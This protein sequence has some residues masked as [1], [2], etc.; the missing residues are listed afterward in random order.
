[1][2]IIRYSLI[3]VVFL[4]IKDFYLWWEIYSQSGKFPVL[5]LFLLNISGLIIVLLNL[6]SYDDTKEEAI[7]LGIWS[8][9][10]VLAGV[11]S[12][13]LGAA[14]GMSGV[15][16]DIVLPVI[17]YSFFIS[18]AILYSLLIIRSQRKYKKIRVSLR[19]ILLILGVVGFSAVSYILVS[20]QRLCEYVNYEFTPFNKAMVKLIS[21]RDESDAIELLK[22]GLDPNHRNVCGATLLQTASLVGNRNLVDVLLDNSADPNIRNSFGETSVYMA[23][24]WGEVEILESLLASGGNPDITTDA[25]EYTPLMIATLNNHAA[26]VKLL[27]SYGADVRYSNSS[28]KSALTIAKESQ[29][30]ELLKILSE[31]I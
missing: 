27:V 2:K 8:L 14:F 5:S 6:F 16:F 24:R 18:P 3:L 30:S 7:L 11:V 28:G 20:P 19:K 9:L 23:A 26:V 22:K 31:G 1:M 29:N 13:N 17:V 4:L 12:S 10:F 15:L 21:R 25:P